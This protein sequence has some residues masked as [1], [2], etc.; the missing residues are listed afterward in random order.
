MLPGGYGGMVPGGMGIGGS[1]GGDIV[2][3]LGDKGG[4]EMMSMIP[5]LMRMAN[6]GGPRTAASAGELRQLVSVIPGR[7]EGESRISRFTGAQQR[8]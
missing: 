5:Q 6:R 4:G 8:P 2:G 7:S 3:M 1:G